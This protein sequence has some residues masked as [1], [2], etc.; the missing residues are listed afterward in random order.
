[1]N[2]IGGVTTAV[3][4]AMSLSG[5][6]RSATHSAYISRPVPNARVLLVPDLRGGWAGWSVATGY[7]TA[8][9]GSSGGG[10]IT[11]TSTGPIFAQAGCEAN[12][13]AIQ[14]YALTTSEV[15][16]V[17]VYGGP[18]IPT[19]TNATLPDGL[20]AAAVEVVRRNGHPNIGLSCPRLTALDAHGKP[21]RWRGNPGG[22][23][24]FKLPG[25]K[26]WTRGAPSEHPA[27]NARHPAYGAC[28]LT[29][30]RLPPETSAR[31]GSV[32][33]KIRPV[34][35][36]IGQAFLSCVNITYFYLGEHALTAAVLLNASHPGARPP[37]LPG[38]RP[39]AGHPGIFEAPG[40]GNEMAARR[41]PGAWLVVEE[42][43]R[44]G[45][46]VSVEILEHLHPTIRL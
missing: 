45:L 31:W 28:E 46:G 6:A 40:D 34:K 7:R 4:C 35:G 43:D 36:L 18:S 29:A 3:I 26:K 11:A 20:R 21:M 39:L 13:A 17:S 24:A 9:E 33:T 16:A 32:A 27:G 1:M 30:T 41:I 14:I 37:R 2:F 42:G 12:E 25:T 10:E 15:A 8:T 5:C 22:P 38:M 19:M 23:Q 44:I